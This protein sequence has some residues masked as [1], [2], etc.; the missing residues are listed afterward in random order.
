MGELRCAKS[1]CLPFV[2]NAAR[3]CVQRHAGHVTERPRL[4]FPLARSATAQVNY[5]YV[6]IGHAIPRGHLT[7]KRALTGAVQRGNSVT[8]SIADTSNWSFDSGRP[9]EA[10]DDFNELGHRDRLRQIGLATALAD[11]LLVAP[12][13]KGGYRD[14]RNG[15]ELRVSLEPLRHFET[16]DFRQ[17]NVHQDQ[18]G[19]VLAGEIERLH[20]VARA[21][22]MVAVSLQQVVEELHVEL[23]VLHNHHGLRHTGPSELN[24][25]PTS[26]TAGLAVISLGSM[27]ASHIKKGLWPIGSGR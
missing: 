14:H 24:R 3:H 16:G 15:L 19:T 6:Q 8:H 4:G 7:K 1:V 27:R 13:R 12:H 26:V 20:A 25:R 5:S 22:G 10:A 23:I 11:A 9:R 2:L 17:L 21:D 18:I